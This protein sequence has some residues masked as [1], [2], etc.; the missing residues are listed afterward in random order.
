MRHFWLKKLTALHLRTFLLVFFKSVS[1]P[2]LAVTIL[3]LD[4]PLCFRAIKEKVYS[5]TV[6]QRSQTQQT[7]DTCVCV[8]VCVCVCQWVGNCTLLPGLVD[9]NMSDRTLQ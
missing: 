8:C 5:C 2:R 3:K 4:I 6:C 1:L 7:S 9:V